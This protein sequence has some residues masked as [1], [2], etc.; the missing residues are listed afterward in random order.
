MELLKR[1]KK[2]SSSVFMKRL[3]GLYLIKTVFI[4]LPATNATFCVRPRVRPRHL[5]G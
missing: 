4:N 1:F 5:V 3:L 2:K